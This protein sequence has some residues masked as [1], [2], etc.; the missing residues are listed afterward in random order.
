MA[1]DLVKQN[2]YEFLQGFL[3]RPA[4]SIPKGAQ[5]IVSFDDLN[6][7]LPAIEKAYSYEP[8][9]IGKWAT[10]QA[11]STILTDEYQKNKGCMFCQAIGLP[12]DGT[13]AVV[14][15]NIKSNGYIRSYVGA[16]RNDFPIMRMTFVD[17]NISFADSFLRGWSLATAN[18]GLIMRSNPKYRTNLTCHKFA[19]TPKGP[20]IIQ[21][22]KFKDICCIGVSEEEYQYGPVTSP[23][24][25]EA[26]F[27]YNNY[28]VDT[29]SGNS[30][31]IVLNNRVEK[32]T[33]V[34]PPQSEYRAMR[35]QPEFRPEI[36]L[37]SEERIDLSPEA[38]AR[39]A[40][41][42]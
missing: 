29:E 31:E 2:A 22:M 30:S 32:A 35:Y 19:I 7:L 37:T 12:G 36:S 40:Q 8:N 15:G 24:L 14:E 38:V 9:N 6:G 1:T 23:I 18:F 26:R 25:R 28:M 39:Q 11:A 41:G 17:T 13:D 3:T 4:S 21:T 42:R 10:T 16:G 33:P 20:F 27:V 5:W 34:N